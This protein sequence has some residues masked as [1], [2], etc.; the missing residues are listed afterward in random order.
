MLKE[1]HWAKVESGGDTLQSMNF[2]QESWAAFL[3]GKS[4][5][6]GSTSLQLSF[7]L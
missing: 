1:T 5:H 7:S 4:I 2:Q 3:L 6:L